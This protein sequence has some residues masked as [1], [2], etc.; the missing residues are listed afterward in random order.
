VTAG[1]AAAGAAYVAALTILRV[2]EFRRL[3]GRY[4]PD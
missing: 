3:I 1:I 4:R 2:E